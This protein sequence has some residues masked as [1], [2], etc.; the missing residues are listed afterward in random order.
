MIPE[1][2]RN[3]G[4]S[5]GMKIKRK[6]LPFNEWILVVVRFGALWKFRY[7]VWPRMECD[8]NLYFKVSDQ[9]STKQWSTAQR[10]TAQNNATQRNTM[11][12]NTT[13]LNVSV[14]AQIYLWKI[15]MQYVQKPFFSFFSVE[16]QFIQTMV[17]IYVHVCLCGECVNDAE[18]D[19]QIK[20][21]YCSPSAFCNHSFYCCH[22]LWINS[23]KISFVNT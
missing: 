20:R 2:N 13:L 16:T 23:A 7:Q 21:L 18:W 14:F 17:Y 8:A 19:F 10:N 5:E 4:K 9:N 3:I 1:C 12:H 11:Q 6:R 15:N 22:H